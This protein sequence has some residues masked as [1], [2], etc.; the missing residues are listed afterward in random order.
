M[1][2][3]LITDDLFYCGVKIVLKNSDNKILLLKKPV[4]DK[5]F[6]ELPG[7]RIQI[8]ETELDALRREMAE[9]TGITTIDNIHHITMLIS[10]YR[11]ATNDNQQVGLIFSVFG[12]TTESDTVTLSDDHKEYMWVTQEQATQLVDDAYGKLF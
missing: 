4:K 11:C 7:G 9:E 6:W 3:N 5:D 10:K 1:N 8:G 12:G 2:K